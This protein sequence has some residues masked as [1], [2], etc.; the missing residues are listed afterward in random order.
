MNR[1]DPARL[2]TIAGALA[3]AVMMLWTMVDIGARLAFNKPLHG[4][5]DLVEVTLV[6]VAFLALPECFRRDEQ[7]KVDLFDSMV[8]PRTLAAMRLA[9]EIATLAFLVLL[10]VTLTQPL[11]DAYR[12]GDQKPDLPVPIFLLLLAIELALV[13]S[14][15]VVLGRIIGQ[16]RAFPLASSATAPRPPALHGNNGAAS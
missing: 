10:A 9:G 4:T 12:F 7:I 1:L 13:V 11:A 14:V 15:F 6:L 3:L 16:V 2:L 5:L 8:R